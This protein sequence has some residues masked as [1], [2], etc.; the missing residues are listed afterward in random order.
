MRNVN[1]G[2][3]GPPM[4]YNCKHQSAADPLKCDAFPAG[5]PRR[6][7]Y[8]QFDHRKPF[9][10]DRG[11]LFDPPDASIPVPPIDDEPTAAGVTL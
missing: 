9:E 7:L 6:I 11:I 2:E 10:G 4:C 3:V 1:L 8:S 5:I